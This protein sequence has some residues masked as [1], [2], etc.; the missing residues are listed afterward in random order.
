LKWSCRNQHG[1]RYS[2]GQTAAEGRS[3]L[4]VSCRSLYRASAW[5]WNGTATPS[6]ATLSRYLPSGFLHRPVR[7]GLPSAVFGKGA[8]R[9]GL[10]PGKRGVLGS[11]TFTHCANNTAIIAR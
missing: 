11:G 3:L 2:V 9:F 7:S 8:E 1:V 5:G 4:K 10:P 6:A